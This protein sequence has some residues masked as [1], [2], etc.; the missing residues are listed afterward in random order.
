M[1]QVKSSLKD[2]AKIIYDK[3]YELK[4]TSIKDFTAYVMSQYQISI[5]ES[6]FRRR[7]YDVISVF[8]CLGYVNKVDGNLEWIGKESTVQKPPQYTETQ[9]RI[10]AKQQIL[11]QKARMLLIYKTLIKENMRKT[12]GNNEARVYIPFIYFECPTNE[13]HI[14]NQDNHSVMMLLGSNTS[15]LSPSEVLESIPFHVSS[16]MQAIKENPEIQQCLD[17]LDIDL[18]GKSENDLIFI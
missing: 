6:S 2:L 14:E 3:L 9:N 1:T 4:N 16:I 17:I 7:I 5:P 15:T 13:I 10:E 11:R 18:S 8:T 12:K